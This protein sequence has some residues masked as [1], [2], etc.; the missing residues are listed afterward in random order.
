MRRTVRHIDDERYRELM[1]RSAWIPFRQSLPMGGVS[2]PLWRA[3]GSAT[4][5]FPPDWTEAEVEVF[6]RGQPFIEFL[7]VDFPDAFL[8]ALPSLEIPSLL[9]DE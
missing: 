2:R 3:A 7:E 9:I 5:I 1:L 8:E 4:F 6:M